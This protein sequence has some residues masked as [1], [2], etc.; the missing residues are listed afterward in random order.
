M[1]KTFNYPVVVK[2]VPAMGLSNDAWSLH[3]SLSSGLADSRGGVSVVKH[4]M[5]I[6]VQCL[7]CAFI[8]SINLYGN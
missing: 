6:N 7:R 5:S 2:L 4:T 8:R 1:F 3:A